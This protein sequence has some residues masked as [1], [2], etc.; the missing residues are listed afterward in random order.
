MSFLRCMVDM[1]IYLRLSAEGNCPSLLVLGSRPL[2]AIGR[3]HPY[4][5]D[6]LA[7]PSTPL[8]GLISSHRIIAWRAALFVTYSRWVS[9]TY[10]EDK[11][12]C[13]TERFHY[14]RYILC[15]T[16]MLVLASSGRAICLRTYPKIV[17]L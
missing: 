14:N 10:N 5:P 11:Y 2:W 16:T 9:R 7:L 8:W 15:G 12:C 13:G 1:T 17:L 3:R 4:G 6:P